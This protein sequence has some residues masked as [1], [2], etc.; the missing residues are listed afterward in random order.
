LSGDASEA[1]IR[2]LARDL[3]PVRPI[4][5]IRT[6]VTGVI[7]LWLAAAA[8][9]LTALGL[10]P[11]L[12]DA[13]FGVR[14]VAAVFAG[15]GLAGLG[16]VVAALAMGVPGR[17][18]LARA[19]LALAILGLL[20]A[21]GVGTLLFAANPAAEVGLTWTSDLACLAVAVLVGLLPAVG[22]V[23]FAG[24]TLLFRPVMAVLAVAAATA[25]LGAITAEGSCTHSE[26]RHLLVAHALAPAFGVLLLTLPL[27]VALRRFRRPR[28]GRDQGLDSSSSPPS[29]DSEPRP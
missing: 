5:R 7:A 8:I 25:A 26:M 14:G 28:Q 11:D 1:L 27:L 13:L 29:G 9:G 6:V 4:P 24:R 16:G 17:E 23:W 18:L 22:V 19:A 10:R 3:D 21:T 12:G 15:L 20:I 2:E